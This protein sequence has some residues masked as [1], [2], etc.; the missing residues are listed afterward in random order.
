MPK[1][2]LRP[3][4]Q[5]GCPALVESGYCEGHKGKE[6]DH[7]QSLRSLKSENES[8]YHTNKWKRT[9]EA[10]RAANPFCAP[11]KRSGI[12]E[13]VHT[14]HHVPELSILL[15]E[16]KDPYDWQYLE[17]V[18]FNCHQKELRRKR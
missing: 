15:K 5:P 7:K 14:A 12:I 11:C 16:G 4:K 6:I 1:R 18:C 17:A 13:R 3:C 10:F 2:A 8:F 9:S